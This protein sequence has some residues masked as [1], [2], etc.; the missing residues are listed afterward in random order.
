[1][2]NI[3]M[4]AIYFN[5]WTF[6]HCKL[7]SIWLVWKKNQMT[8]IRPLVRSIVFNLEQLKLRRL[9]T[10]W[11]IKRLISLGRQ[12]TLC[13]QNLL[14]NATRYRKKSSKLFCYLLIRQLIVF[15]I[16][17]SVVTVVE[18]FEIVLW[19]YLNISFNTIWL[20]LTIRTYHWLTILFKVCSNKGR[21]IFINRN[22]LQIMNV[23]DW[24]YPNFRKYSCYS[25]AN[26]QYD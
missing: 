12:N 9:M 1:M 24:W 15:V 26:F 13:V 17:G 14:K 3:H 23:N 4:K 11:N 8:S 6:I 2:M 5:N 7:T 18:N 19:F 25:I 21:Y 22:I 20:P 16:A 10:G